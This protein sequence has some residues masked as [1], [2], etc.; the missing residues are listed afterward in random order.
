ME[1]NTAHY[2]LTNVNNLIKSGKVRATNS[3]YIGARELGINDLDGMCDVIS[4]LSSAD[5]YKSMTTHEDHRIWQDVYHAK[6]ANGD[7]VYLKL[8]VTDNVLIVSFKEL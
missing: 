6:T 1:K 7:D 2:R 5:F 3:A 8:T 4:T